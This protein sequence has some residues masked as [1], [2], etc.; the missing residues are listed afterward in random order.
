M[1]RHNKES[2]VQNIIISIVLTNGI[3]NICQDNLNF[4][5]W[6]FLGSG[7]YVTSAL[8]SKNKIENNKKEKTT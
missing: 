7:V 2:L 6:F 3:S 5:Y 1:K 8:F 4:L